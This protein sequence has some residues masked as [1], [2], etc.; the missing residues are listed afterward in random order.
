MDSE[1]YLAVGGHNKVDYL[2]TFPANFAVFQK[3]QQEKAGRKMTRI[4]LARSV[5]RPPPCNGRGGLSRLGLCALTVQGLAS[6]QNSGPCTPLQA[7]RVFL[8]PREGST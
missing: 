5:P 3:K 7:A 4:P 1:A 6:I 2:W 8:A